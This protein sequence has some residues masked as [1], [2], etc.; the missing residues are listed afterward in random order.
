M[1]VVIKPYT[2]DLIPAVQAFNRRLAAGGV[3]SR[4]LFPEHHIPPWLPRLDHGRLYH[5]LLLAVENDSVRGG[6]IITH[7]DFSFQGEVRSIGYYR[8]PISEGIVSKAHVMVGVQML[9][10]A[11]E[12]QPLLFALGMGGCDR[13][14]PQILNRMGWN[15]WLLPF[16][17]KVGSPYRLLKQLRPLRTTPVRRLLA[18]FA[19]VTG[20]GWLGI[21]TIQGLRN[22]RA[23][24][25]PSVSVERVM[26]F[27]SWADGLWQQCKARYAMIAVRD[28][29][30]L[31]VLYPAVNNR[32]T[33]LKISRG[34]TV[35]GWAV[36]LDTPMR[37]DHY[38]GDLRVGSLVDCLALPE[39]APAVARSATE[40]L[41][42]RGVDVIISNQSHAFWSGALR[43]AGFQ[44][45]PSNFV[46]AASKKL[47]ELLHP[48]EGRKG[49]VHLN[50]GDGDGPINL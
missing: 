48:F 5:D 6:C 43:D 13:P 33:R 38:F 28:H 30:T 45:G 19:A 15:L 2:E 23:V 31:N 16:H 18:N 22:V 8:H 10:S 37:D 26:A 36:L 20:L 50:R 14:L 24:G 17:F 12:R 7:Q 40:V 34:G 46:F 29:E 1:A 32:F 42:R 11:L 4:Y 41:E 21:K 39:N 25:D 3:A 49:Q 27:S 44:R 47:S 9:R 35:L